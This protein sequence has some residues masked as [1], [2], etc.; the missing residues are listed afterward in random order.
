MFPI[1]TLP[2]AEGAREALIRHCVEFYRSRGRASVAALCE[3]EHVETFRRLGFETLGRLGEFTFH[4]SLMRRWQMLLTA[5]YERVG[6]RSV[7][8][9]PTA[10]DQA[11]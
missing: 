5:M 8:G 10:E 6:S 9:R 4:K 2:D 7:S 1:S 3:D 11:A